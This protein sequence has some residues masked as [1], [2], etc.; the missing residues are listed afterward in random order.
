MEGSQAVQERTTTGPSSSL[1]P[2]E[3]LAQI[4]EEARAQIVVAEEMEAL[5]FAK[6]LEGKAK[7]VDARAERKRIG[8]AKREKQQL[9]EIR[10]MTPE[11][12]VGFEQRCNFFTPAMKA[13]LRR[14]EGL[15]MEEQVPEPISQP[16]LGE[17]TPE[18]LRQELI[19][20]ERLIGAAPTPP[21]SS[22]LVEDEDDNVLSD[23]PPMEEP[24]APPVESST[25]PKRGPGR[26]RKED[27]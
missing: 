27:Q 24:I 17:A 22:E 23:E 19:R 14:L 4:Q 13:E 12:R 3:R 7:V 1:L 6:K 21:S 9:D 8:L 18:Q 10:A 5:K 16:S 11:Q 15:P 20:K 26:P 2:P 25:K